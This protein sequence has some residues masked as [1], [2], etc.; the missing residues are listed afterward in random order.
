[1]FFIFDLLSTL[2]LAKPDGTGDIACPL[3][4]TSSQLPNP[5]P[6]L[7]KGANFVNS[8][9]FCGFLTMKGIHVTVV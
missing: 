9:I 5:V 4:R 8:F 6:V 3:Q 7:S 1:L 2:N